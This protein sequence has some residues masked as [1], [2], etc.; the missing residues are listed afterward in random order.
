[1]QPLIGHA[2]LRRELAALAASPEPPHA[3]LFAGPE[4]TGRAPLARY[5]AMLFNCEALHPAPPA[6]ASFFGD[7]LPPV[8]PAA[9]PGEPC[10]ACRPC[11]LIAEGAHPD[12][13]TVSP[14]D[15]LCKPR[16]GESHPA[17]PD[18]AD[19]RICQVR[20]ITDLVARYPFEARTR[21]IIID[22]ADRLALYAASALLKTLEEPPGH[23]VFC[24][25]TAAPERLLETIISRC[26]RIDVRPVPRADIEAGLLQ[27]GVEP[28]RAAEAA[29]AARGR[30]GRALAFVA[31]P[32]LIGARG[33][34]LER[35]AE[36]AAAGLP[37]RFD[38]ARSLAE[39]WRGDQ[40]AVRFEL[41]CWE[42]YWEE[43]LRRA[44]A[45]GARQE[46]AG[47]LEALRA[48]A[49]VREHLLANVQA[50]AAFDL[51]LLRF[52]RVTLEPSTE[53]ELPAHA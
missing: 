15:A 28:E 44:A 1:M 22:P 6:G 48:I 14:G 25:L 45:A 24:L 23:T 12:V 50:R 5:L 53:E 27:R 11:R 43:R 29:A 42:A 33:R 40:A 7:D 52:P 10:G 26:R 34:I 4:S 19:I 41:E 3:L 47:L 2:A 51:M 46:L 9:N 35:C 21:V 31:E 38:Y 20:G 30:P 18:S 49:A 36:I 16:D 32:D 39:R 13:I 17:H 8:A 37:A